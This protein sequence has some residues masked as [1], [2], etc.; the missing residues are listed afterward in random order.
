MAKSDS[1][2][3]SWKKGD[4]Q[5]YK[6]TADWKRANKKKSTPKPSGKGKK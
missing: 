2:K 3:F 4:V 5:V 6:N 1:N